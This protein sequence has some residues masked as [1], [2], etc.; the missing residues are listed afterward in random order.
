MI[1]KVALPLAL[2]LSTSTAVFAQETTT[3]GPDAN[4]AGT[5]L[6]WDEE[7]TGAFFEGGDAGVLL[8]AEEIAANWSDLT[9]EQQERVQLDCQNIVAGDASP[10]TVPNDPAPTSDRTANA[11]GTDADADVAT[12]APPVAPSS[13]AAPTSER[14]ATAMGTETTSETEASDAMTSQDTSVEMQQLCAV[15]AE[16]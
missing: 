14:T 1:S 11:M 5:P 2:V 16:L 8:D 3:S 15:V 7:I 10:G 9:S 13:E 6:G 4:I 12:D